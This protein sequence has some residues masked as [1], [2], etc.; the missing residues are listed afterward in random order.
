MDIT[1]CRYHG[2]TLQVHIIIIIQSNTLDTVQSL[3]GECPY[4]LISKF[5]HFNVLSC[6]LTECLEEPQQV[7]VG[8][9]AGRHLVNAILPIP[10][11]S[12]AGPDVSGGRRTPP[13]ISVRPRKTTHRGS[14]DRIVI[15]TFIKNIYNYI[16]L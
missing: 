3:A 2:G 5:P 14:S 10:Q 12:L 1:H 11:G 6:V 7:G 9:T 15:V 16:Y 8:S 13:H 4:H